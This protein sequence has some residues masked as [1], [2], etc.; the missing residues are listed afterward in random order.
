MKYKPTDFFVFTTHFVIC[1]L[2][3]DYFQGEWI[4]QIGHT[5]FAKLTSVLNYISQPGQTTTIL[6]SLAQ[7][8][9]REAPTEAKIE[10]NFFRPSYQVIE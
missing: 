6:I 7:T 5:A 1:W 4:L 9:M 2:F 3:S 10:S 8:R